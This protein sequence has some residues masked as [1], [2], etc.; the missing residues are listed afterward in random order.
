M[1]R[2][3]CSPS[4]T[5][6]RPAIRAIVPREQCRLVVAS[7][8]QPRGVQRDRDNHLRT[9]QQRRAR[10]CH[11]GRQYRRKFH[12][13]GMLQRQHQA[14]RAIVVAQ[15]SAGLAEARRHV[16][17]G[18]ARGPCAAAANGT[19]QRSHSGS[20][21]KLTCAKQALQSRAWAATSS[22]Q[23]GQRGGRTRSSV[24]AASRRKRG[25]RTPMPPVWAAQVQAALTLAP[26]RTVPSRSISF[27][28][29]ISQ[30]RYAFIA[31]S[32]PE[33][34]SYGRR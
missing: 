6:G 18:D 7:P 22:A 33:L 34:R 25:C 28:R 4:S 31:S 3:R 13:V 29:S 8:P 16:L 10:A 32:I 21:M 9:C 14:A 12:P 17:A 11:P 26:K 27:T 1:P 20:V 5:A 30:D 15:C 19:P 24:S 2:T 23:A